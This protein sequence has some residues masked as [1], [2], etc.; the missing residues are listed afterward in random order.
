MQLHNFGI[1]FFSQINNKKPSFV[2][3][4]HFKYQILKTPQLKNIASLFKSLDFK[5]LF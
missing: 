1:N 3:F 4:K 5:N 2:L